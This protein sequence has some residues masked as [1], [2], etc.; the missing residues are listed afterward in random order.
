MKNIFYTLLVLTLFMTACHRPEVG[1]LG[2][3]FESRVD[4]IELTRGLFDQGPLPFIDGSTLP[5]SWEITGATDAEGNLTNDLFEPRDIVLW[6]EAYNPN[7]DTTAALVN[8]KLD[9]TKKPSIYINKVSGQLIVTQASRTVPQDVYNLN[10]KV[11]NI[12][13]ERQLDHFATLKLL[14]YKPAEVRFA[15]ISAIKLIRKNGTEATIKNQVNT[16]D[17]ERIASV[18]NEEGTEPDP[19][20][21]IK[22]ISDEP[23]SSVSVRMILTDTDGN[24]ISPSKVTRNEAGAGSDTEYLPSF[25]ENSVETTTDDEATIFNFP[26]PPFPQYSSNFPN[27]TT[28]DKMY[29]MF[30]RTTTEAINLVGKPPGG[31]KKYQTNSQGGV[32]GYGY[33]R[34]GLRINDFGTWEIK[35][36]IPRSTVMTDE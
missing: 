35:A 1:F 3:A 21:S 2:T 14:P 29:Q 28:N 20:F 23:A 27:A 11:S 24:V 22:K 5:L 16:N 32:L 10:L 19:I 33:V 25:N 4:T 31:V 6:K 8:E 26:A 18:L 12:S 15:M 36:A 30:Y 9:R 7:T 17:E 34:W 13:G